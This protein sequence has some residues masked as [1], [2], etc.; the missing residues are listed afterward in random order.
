MAILSEKITQINENIINGKTA[1]AEAI[2]NKGVE[3]SV[4]ASFSEMAENIEGITSGGAG[5]GECIGTDWGTIE[6]IVYPFKFP[7]ELIEENRDNYP[8][9][10]IFNSLEFDGGVGIILFKEPFY[11]GT[12]FTNSNLLYLTSLEGE[13]PG[14]GVSYISNPDG[15]WNKKS[16][17]EYV[18]RVKGSDNR[19][20]PL[21]LYDFK[22]V[23]NTIYFNRHSLIASELQG[24]EVNI[25]FLGEAPTYKEVRQNRAG[26]DMLSSYRGKSGQMVINLDNN[27]L[28]IMDGETPGGVPLAKQE[29]IEAIWEEINGTS[30]LLDELLEELV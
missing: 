2:S 28:H 19:E 26:N 16:Q 23:N 10:I 15:S 22:N 5:G 12:G 30:S 25:T 4:S 3:T 14:E 29:S 11:Y 27:T 24:K 20:E 6:E 8:Y 17:G 13:A 9:Y 21:E 1:I 7:K 18:W